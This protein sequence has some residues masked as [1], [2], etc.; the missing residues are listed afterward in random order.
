MLRFASLE[1]DLTLEEQGVLGLRAVLCQISELAQSTY[2]I[3]AEPADAHHK[4]ELEDQDGNLVAEPQARPV[5]P[6]GE[7]RHLTDQLHE[8][9]RFLIEADVEERSLLLDQLA[10]ELQDLLLG[11]DAE[12]D[13]AVELKEDDAVTEE[14]TQP[15]HDRLAHHGERYIRHILLL[16]RTVRDDLPRRLLWHERRLHAERRFPRFSARHALTAF[17]GADP[18]RLALRGAAEVT[19][20]S[21]AKWIRA[22]E[23][24]RVEL[25]ARRG[26]KGPTPRHV[27][28]KHR[29]FVRPD[30]NGEAAEPVLDAP[31]NGK[32][33]VAY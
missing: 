17:W 1:H 30:G 31:R 33:G 10:L 22:R 29:R 20:G 25:L 11:E 21:Q 8:E 14:E 27:G 18:C 7:F 4:T 19:C 13:A 16:Q 24:S 23:I 12:E 15:G 9:G 3:H 6:A 26:D 28:Q 5:V 32:L 2:L